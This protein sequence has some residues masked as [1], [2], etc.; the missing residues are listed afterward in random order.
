MHPT[1]TSCPAPGRADITGALGVPSSRRR[2][3]TPCPRA[4]GTEFAQL[5]RKL[6]LT[7]TAAAYLAGYAALGSWATVERRGGPRKTLDS[8]ESAWASLTPREQGALS[9]TAKEQFR[10]R[11]RNSAGRHPEDYVPAEDVRELCALLRIRAPAAA[12][13]CGMNLNLFRA[14]VSGEY[15]RVRASEVQPIADLARYI[16]SEASKTK[17]SPIAFQDALTLARE[18]HELFE[19]YGMSYPDFDDTG[20]L[21]IKGLPAASNP[22]SEKLLRL[23]ESVRAQLEARAALRRAGF[24]EAVPGSWIRGLVTA[25]GS[26]Q[27]VVT[28]AAKYEIEISREAVRLWA[29]SPEPISGGKAAQL[30]RAIEADLPVIRQRASAQLFNLDAWRDV[31]FGFVARRESALRDLE[32]GSAKMLP[33]AV[34]I[35]EEAGTAA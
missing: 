7:Q 35:P 5:R 33:A 25:F 21:V 22:R 3:P 18:S 8:V 14:K 17:R 26:L 2:G 4:E 16:L 15:V 34:A 6:G 30:A 28:L 1:T 23:Y 27:G 11:V 10:A 19:A 9:A 31:V 13:L 20:W 24:G 12:K 32:T 29:S